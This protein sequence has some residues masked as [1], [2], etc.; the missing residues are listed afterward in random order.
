[1]LVRTGSEDRALSPSSYQKKRKRKVS[2][3]PE[4]KYGRENLKRKMR[5]HED[6]SERE[7]YNESPERR[8]RECY[9]DRKYERSPEGST[10][11]HR[12]YT[13]TCD[14]RSRARPDTGGHGGYKSNPE[15]SRHKSRS[16]E[17]SKQRILTSKRHYTSSSDT[18]ESSDSSGS[19]DSSCDSK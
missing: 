9:S 12:E 4:A 6:T 13:E 18:S 11:R 2:S 7:K 8:R 3:S 10:H 15:R 16:P 5:Y 17:A 19:S 1:M 14:H